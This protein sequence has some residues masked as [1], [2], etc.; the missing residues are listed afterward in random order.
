VKELLD[1]LD[2]PRRL[3][4]ATRGLFALRLAIPRGR[5][6]GWRRWLIGS[7]ELADDS[8]TWYVD[9][10]M[11]DGKWQGT[12]RTGFG[13]VIVGPDGGV[14]GIALGSPPSWVTSAAGAEAWALLEVLQVSPGTPKIVTDCLGLIQQL[15]RGGT[16]ATGSRRPLARLWRLIFSVLDGQVPQEWLHREFVWMG[17]HSSKAAIG[18]A[19]KSNGE[20]VSATDWRANRLA[21]GLAKMAAGRFRVPEELRRLLRT[22]DRL[23][24]YSAAALGMQTHAANNYQHTAWRDDGTAYTTKLRDATPRPYWAHG[25]GVRPNA[26]GTR[27][28]QPNP[29]AEPTK[30]AATSAPPPAAPAETA[31]ERPREADRRLRAQSARQDREAQAETR[32]QTSWHLDQAQA[33]RA[34]QPRTAAARLEELRLRVLRRAGD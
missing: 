4:V 33:P 11:V 6:G 24:E 7:P 25:T 28:K 18:R 12:A 34:P 1:R 26:T 3:L 32:F 19:Q 15:E 29:D 21:D 5:P 13:I 31:S 22:A 27:A 20:V 17:S 10:S 8:C 14:R 30:E 23:V 2:E 9:G 16:D